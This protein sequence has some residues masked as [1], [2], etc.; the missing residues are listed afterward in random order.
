[1]F[2]HTA[3]FSSL[4]V[5][6]LACSG[7]S[8]ATLSKDDVDRES[9]R[10][11]ATYKIDKQ[12]CNSL[13]GNRK[14]ICTEEAKGK[15]AVAKADLNY[16][17]TGT[18]KDR[19]AV[20]TARAS[21]AYELAK[22]R[23]DDLGGNTKDVCMKEAKADEVKAMANI[24]QT[25]GAAAVRTEAAQDKADADYKVAA[26]KCDFLAGDAKDACIQSAKSRFGKS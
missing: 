3:L 21:A 10:I 7:A 20:D 22:E 17:R 2:K 25:S 26:E 11:A 6:L 14:D 16:R 19:L 9:E 8:A 15:E 1:M 5:G 4:L 12:A 23:C 18:E 24:K 13:S